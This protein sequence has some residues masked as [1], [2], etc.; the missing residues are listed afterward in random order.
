MGNRVGLDVLDNALRHVLTEGL[1]ELLAEDSR[2]DVL[3]GIRAL[4]NQFGEKWLKFLAVVEGLLLQVR[5][6][7]CADCLAN[8]EHEDKHALVVHK[9]DIENTR[10]GVREKE[11]ENLIENDE[12]QYENV[13][14]DTNDEEEAGNDW[15]SDD[16]NGKER[17]LEGHVVLQHF[18]FHADFLHGNHFEGFNFAGKTDCKR[19]KLSMH[20]FESKL[21]FLQVRN[22]P[23]DF[24]CLTR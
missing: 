19:A 17:T 18:R 4:G 22:T 8:A 5:H 11:G 23:V 21:K 2:V 3:V 20:G 13:G 14:E 9:C 12:W 16:A 15:R 10:G 1:D 7:E 6:D 24:F